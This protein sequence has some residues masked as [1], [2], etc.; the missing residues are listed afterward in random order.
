MV[1]KQIS[2]AVAGGTEAEE[3]GEGGFLRKGDGM[4]DVGV[5]ARWKE[6]RYHGC[7]HC[8]G[9]LRNKQVVSPVVLQQKDG[10]PGL[11]F[12][13]IVGDVDNRTELEGFPG[14]PEPVG[15]LC[16]CSSMEDEE[17]GASHFRR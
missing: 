5:L 7:C 11:S 13:D 16:S 1:I 15:L 9:V 3:R 8:D 17:W 14:E 4:A 2:G 12:I 10:W 6:S